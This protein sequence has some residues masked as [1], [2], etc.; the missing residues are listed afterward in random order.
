ME[1]MDTRLQAMR[2]LRD[3]AATADPH[4]HLV[5]LIDILVDDAPVATVQ[6]PAPVLVDVVPDVAPVEAPVEAPASAEPEA[7][8]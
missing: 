3:E 7:A 1:G 5:R 8:V 4:S 2:D 6:A